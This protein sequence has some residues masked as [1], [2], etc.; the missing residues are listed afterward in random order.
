MANDET[1][2][3]EKPIPD[4]ALRRLDK[5]VGTWSLKGRTLDAQED[6]IRGRTTIEW[7]PGGFFLALRGEI[8]FQGFKS[9]SLEVIGYDP[10]T[11]GFSSTVYSDMGGVP[12]PYWWD[13][14]DDVVTHWM[15]GSKYTGT[16]SE[17]GNV[18]KG[19]WRP[20]EGKESAEN[21]GY[22][23]IMIRILDA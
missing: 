16:F 9:Q 20:D 14:Q 7:L 18:L 22:D 5:L 8:E 15:E 1:I 19:G 3:P 4:P 6:N 11:R 23:A 13:V 12:M 2:L 10:T 21:V 17:D